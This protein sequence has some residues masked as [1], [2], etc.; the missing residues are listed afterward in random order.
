[1]VPGW[2]IVIGNARVIAIAIASASVSVMSGQ[3]QKMRPVVEDG[4]TQRQVL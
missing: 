2:E 1:M 4:A 3:R